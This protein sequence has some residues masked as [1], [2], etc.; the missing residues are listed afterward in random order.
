MFRDSS[1]TRAGIFFGVPLR[2]PWMDFGWLL[3]FL[4]CSATW[5]SCQKRTYFTNVVEENDTRAD[6]PSLFLKG[7]SASKP[8]ILGS[9]L[10]FGECRSKMNTTNS[11]LGHKE[12]G[13]LVAV[14]FHQLY[15]PKTSN[16]STV[17][18]KKTMVH[19]VFQESL[20]FFRSFAPFVQSQ[21]VHRGVMMAFMGIFY[22]GMGAGLPWLDHQN[23]RSWPWRNISSRQS[24]QPASWSP[25]KGREK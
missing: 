22:A 25:Q 19:E 11:R 12:P 24:E 3:L 7:N 4:P 2:L 8:S 21:R 23:S 15:P 13:K 5:P 6:Q 18:N 9:M 10:V 1:G 20:C 17:T 16:S 14:D